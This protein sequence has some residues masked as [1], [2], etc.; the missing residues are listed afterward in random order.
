[1]RL[2][3]ILLSQTKQTNEKPG[4]NYLTPLACYSISMCHCIFACLGKNGDE[5]STNLGYSSSHL[6]LFRTPL[7]T[8]AWFHFNGSACTL[9]G[10]LAE[11][12]TLSLAMVLLCI[13][14]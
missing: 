3:W 11:A 13:S 10:L 12:A 14:S 4:E 5:V 2:G 7:L 1:M 8:P 6:Y 9:F